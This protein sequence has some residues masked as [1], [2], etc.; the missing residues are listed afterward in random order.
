MRPGDRVA[1][2]DDWIES[3]AQAGATREMVLEAGGE[4]VGTACVVDDMDDGDPLRAV[5]GVRALLR[6]AEL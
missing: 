1:C 5:L 2:V 4:F 3:G 6:A